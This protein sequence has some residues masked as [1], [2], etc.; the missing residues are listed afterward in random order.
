MGLGWGG[1]CAAAAA[2]AATDA[3]RAAPALRADA[4]AAPGRAVCFFVRSTA[5]VADTFGGPARALLL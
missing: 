2:T 4:F 5:G 3:E 1:L